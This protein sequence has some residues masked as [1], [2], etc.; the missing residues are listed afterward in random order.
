MRDY[1][2]GAPQARPF[3]SGW[4][5]DAASYEAKA[6]EVDTRFGP[7][8]RRQAAGALRPHDDEARRRLER[9]VE[10]GGYVVTT[11]QQP[12]LFTGPLYSVYKG[13][14]AVLLA[15]TLEAHLERPVLPVFWVASED[16]D[17]AEVNHTFALDAA[18]E[19]HRFQVPD[20]EGASRRPIHRI[21]L[22][23]VLPGVIDAFQAVFPPTDW[24]DEAMALIRACY[25]D[26]CT[27]D[28]GFRDT[29]QALLGPLG[30]FTTDA[31]DPVVKSASA[32]LLDQAITN[33]AEHERVLTAT[34]VRLEAAGYDTQ[35]AVLPDGTNVFMEGPEGR[36]RLYCT[37]GALRFHTSGQTLAVDEVRARAAADPTLLSPNVLLRPVVE[38]VVFPTLSYVGGP[39]EMAYFAQL[40]D[41]FRHQGVQAPVLYPRVSITL[42]EAKVSKV[43]EKF[44]MDVDDLDRPFHEI[45]SG[46]A[47]DEVP[48]DV[49]KALGQIRG[50]VGQG[51]AALEAAART[52]DPTLKGPVQAAR[53]SAF[54]AFQ[55]AE[56]KILQGVKKQSEIALGQLEKAQVNLFPGGAPQE[57]TLNVFQ[58]LVR[59]GRELIPAL[60]ER[61][62]DLVRIKGVEARSSVTP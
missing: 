26:G 52:V 29:I 40:G 49:R 42:V 41:Y 12:G 1:L 32:P 24:R 18:N 17:W 22:E 21:A 46:F 48:D 47:R 33:A 19:L 44:N 8:E 25:P 11:G 10:E 7:E 39:G 6:A 45:A 23:G 34:A 37:D 4:W 16:H 2:A 27:L 59:Y 51:S 55:E 30:L 58:Y 57:R 53:N 14:T 28:Q 56:K 9:F 15:R 3:F 20:P 13:L 54:A 60:A 62:G 36:E 50:A 31:A 38:S 5:G 61:A 35:V 43:L